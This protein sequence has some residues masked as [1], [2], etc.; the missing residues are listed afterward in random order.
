[1][2]RRPVS[3][4][5]KLIK[6]NDYKSFGNDLLVANAARVS[7]AKESKKF[8]IIGEAKRSDEGL[9]N[10]MADP[11]GDGSYD[12]IHFTPFTHPQYLFE[13]TMPTNLLIERYNK[14]QANQ[15]TRVT[16]YNEDLYIGNETVN[17]TTF[18][19][20]GSLYNYIKTNEFHPHIL[21]TSPYSVK[22]F[23]KS[24]WKLITDIYGTNTGIDRELMIDMDRDLMTEKLHKIREIEFDQHLSKNNTSMINLN[25]YIDSTDPS[26]VLDG[27]YNLNRDEYL[28]LIP[29]TFHIEMPIVVANQY[30]RHGVNSQINEVSRRYV[31]DEPEYCIYNEWRM[32]APNI[33]Q[34]SSKELIYSNDIVTAYVADYCKKGTELYNHLLQMNV[35]PELARSFLPINLYTMFYQTGPLSLFDRIC[36]LRDDDHAQKEIR[37]YAIVMKQELKKTIHNRILK[38]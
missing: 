7:M 32:R 12:R 29:A 15:V 35:A 31:D 30:K 37:E 34:G 23:K 25:Q 10:Y 26:V 20:R 22:S 21:K 24:S 36:H 2:I 6:Y 5:V 28:D 27:A 4:L 8:T 11:R 3:E 18:L 33:K 17:F 13:I 14:T 38:Y 16:L 9:L 19:E 1:M